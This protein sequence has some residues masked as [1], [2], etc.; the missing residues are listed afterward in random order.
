MK[1]YLLLFIALIAVLFFCACTDEPSIVRQ[2]P[3]R[4]LDQEAI[5]PDKPGLW[6]EQSKEW[7]LGPTPTE[8]LDLGP[9]P[10]EDLD[11]GPIPTEDLDLGPIPTEAAPTPAPTPLMK[12]EDMSALQ[13]YEELMGYCKQHQDPVSAV[14][15]VLMHRDGEIADDQLE[16]LFAIEGPS[17]G[18]GYSMAQWESMMDFFDRWA[19]TLNGTH[20]MLG[21]NEMQEFFDELCDGATSGGVLIGLLPTYAQRVRAAAAAVHIDGWQET[22]KSEQLKTVEE[23]YYSDELTPAEVV[24]MYAHIRYDPATPET[25]DLNETAWK[26]DDYID[27]EGIYGHVLKAYDEI[28]AQNNSGG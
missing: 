13:K 28:Y 25:F 7:D 15:I 26:T 21:E 14:K 24:L 18:R 4:F 6:E 11:L 19:A 23:F 22:H 20:H 12:D 8:D 1:T 5:A 2:I 10:T 27:S 16:A 3:D 9:I 17:E